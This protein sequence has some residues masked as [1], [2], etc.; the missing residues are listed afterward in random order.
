MNDLNVESTWSTDLLVLQRTL[1]VKCAPWWHAW[2]AWW[3]GW[4][5]R[6]PSSVII[7]MQPP[8]V[9]TTQNSTNNQKTNIPQVWPS[10][11]SVDIFC[12]FS[13]TNTLTIVTIDI[14]NFSFKFRFASRSGLE[15]NWTIESNDPSSKSPLSR[16]N[17]LS[18]S[19][20]LRSELWSRY[21]VGVVMYRFQGLRESSLTILFTPRLLILRGASFGS[22][23][24]LPCPYPAHFTF[25]E[26][27]N[28]YAWR[29]NFSVPNSAMVGALGDARAD[30]HP[31]IRMA[32]K[33]A[34]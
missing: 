21:C 10:G 26:K 17:I 14:N 1:W 16:K 31:Y 32:G 27:N 12:T 11:P 13:F 24:L 34:E 6:G 20:G 4:G 23:R 33:R 8:S 22:S 19:T 5:D 7:R 3:Q 15:D 2:E 9:C 29:T 25:R 18:N 28:V 30:D